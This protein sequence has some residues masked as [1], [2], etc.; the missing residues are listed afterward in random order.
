MA[1]LG[2]ITVR[3]RA[4]AS[5]FTTG[6][7]QA[8]TATK[9]FYE[10]AEQAG[11]FAA[12]AERGIR[13]MEY[14]LGALATEAVG[15]NHSIGMV[16]EGLLL[17]GGGSLAAL[18]A[19]GAIALAFGAFKD[20]TFSTDALTKANDDLF[21]TLREGVG[22]TGDLRLKLDDLSQTFATLQEHIAVLR[23]PESGKSIWE[24][25]KEL[26]GPSTQVQQIYDAIE[27]TTAY[28]GILRLHG[29]I[30]EEVTKKQDERAKSADREAE[31]I[32]RARTE[33]ERAA[34]ERIQRVYE[35]LDR[36]NARDNPARK[37]GM[38]ALA[39][40]FQGA[41]GAGDVIG[42]SQDQID[43][44]TSNVDTV[45]T[46]I[47]AELDKPAAEMQSR[48]YRTGYDAITRL[49][50]GMLQGT[51]DMGK[52]VESV[53]LNFVIH[54]GEIALFG[55][56]GPLSAASLLT[57]MA[58]GAGAVSSISGG[59]RP[60]FNI[61]VPPGS[62]PFD[63]ARDATWQNALRESAVVAGSQGFSFP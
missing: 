23:G 37:A 48:M 2:D 27:A 41:V 10:G 47:R 54:L 36:Q 40:G 7:Q 59:A 55:A 51:K 25:V 21:K 20:A 61:T 49:I 56:G 62:T 18:S 16:T 6:M 9:T 32:D 15:A 53:L 26:F 46:R 28:N 58:A 34:N 13:R 19:L 43:A 14:G 52:L 8:A 5:Q 11:E 39:R 42:M 29:M 12:G 63:A 38:A 31:A 33:D 17:F 30:L 3:L 50:E 22:T 4:D 24:N 57:G 45:M 44:I 1:D 35:E 60:A